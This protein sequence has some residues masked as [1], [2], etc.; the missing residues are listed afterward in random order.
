MTTTRSNFVDLLDPSFRHIIFDEYT[1]RPEYYS[2]FFKIE[3]SNRQ[4]EKISEAT[5]FG[6]FSIKNEGGSIIYDDPKQ[7]YDVEA[8]HLT[9]ALGFRVTEEMLEDD[10]FNVIKRMPRMLAV[11]AKETTEVVAHDVLNSGFTTTYGDGVPLFSLLHPSPHTGYQVNT[12]TA[13]ADLSETS[14]QAALIDFEATTDARGLPLVMNSAVLMVPPALQFTAQKLMAAVLEPE[15]ANNA[16]NAFRN[17]VY[18]TTPRVIVNPYLT[19]ADT[20]FLID[21]DKHSLTFYNRVPLETR[22]DLEFD[23]GDMLFKAR[24]RYSV[25]VGSWRGVYGVPGA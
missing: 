15:T 11:S 2:R 23:S 13:A 16:P 6:L 1:R 5:N 12:P 14:L 17:R 3:S 4:S 21:S 10:Q 18:G 22:S 7:G 25:T 19:D 9:Y 24:M 20:W 8:V